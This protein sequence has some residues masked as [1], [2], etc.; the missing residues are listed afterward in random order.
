MFRSQ[1]Q[2]IKE[3]RPL[4]I[5]P[6]ELQRYL[7]HRPDLRPF[8]LLA[9]DMWGNMYLGPELKIMQWMAEP[10]TQPQADAV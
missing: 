5:D 8:R 2:I 4:G 3:L 9:M 6:V 10:R 7:T 1:C